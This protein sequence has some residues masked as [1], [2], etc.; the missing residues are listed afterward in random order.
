[1]Q[2]ALN[3]LD[4]SYHSLHPAFKVF[5]RIRLEFYTGQAFRFLSKQALEESQYGEAVTFME[6]AHR[7]LKGIRFP[8]IAHST[9]EQA[10]N[11]VKTAIV[12]ILPQLATLRKDNAT[13]YF[14]IIPDIST[15][16]LPN[17]AFIPKVEDFTPIPACSKSY[18]D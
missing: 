6:E 1:M 14:A 13:I 7:W 9:I 5:P 16:P 15:L 8:E 3:G 10:K 18:F 4:A 17:G 12:E 11:Q 2:T